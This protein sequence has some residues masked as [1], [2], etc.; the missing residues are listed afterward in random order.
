MEQAEL[1]CVWACPWLC[2]LGIPLDKVLGAS[3][4]KSSEQPW[5]EWFM[6]SLVSPLKSQTWSRRRL[7]IECSCCVAFGTKLMTTHR[8]FADW[9]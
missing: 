7:T 4:S 2:F 9:K 1:G 3:E 5:P 8:I 6:D